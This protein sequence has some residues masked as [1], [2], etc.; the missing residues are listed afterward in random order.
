ML[1]TR[2]RVL[3]CPPK[4]QPEL[5]WE[6]RCGD[7]RSQKGNEGTGVCLWVTLLSNCHQPEKQSLLPAPLLCPHPRP[8]VLGAQMRVPLAFGAWGAAC[9]HVA[10]SPR[11]GGRRI[12]SGPSSDP[13]GGGP[14]PPDPNPRSMTPALGLR[15]PCSQTSITRLQPISF[16]DSL[17][18]FDFAENSI[19]AVMYYLL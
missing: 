15:T 12:G 9:P 11:G 10:Q 14:D 2:W 16:E 19:V 7:Q 13:R 18:E 6:G 4:R 1:R 17:A 3:S 8:Q 5:C